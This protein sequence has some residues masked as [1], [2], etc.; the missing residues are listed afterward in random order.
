MPVEHPADFE[1]AHGI[2][3]AHR[4]SRAADTRRDEQFGGPEDEEEV[5]VEVAAVKPPKRR[6]DA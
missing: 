2:R 3:G 4:R 6:L 5:A 1:G